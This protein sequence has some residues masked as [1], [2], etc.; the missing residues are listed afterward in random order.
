M[1][2][3]S[4]IARMGKELDKVNTGNNWRKIANGFH[5][6]IKMPIIVAL[7]KDTS[8]VPDLR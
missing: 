4:V 8:I 1:L 7:D 2:F 5:S 6:A 3:L